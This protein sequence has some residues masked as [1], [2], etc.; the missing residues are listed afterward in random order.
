MYPILL[1]NNK[2]LTAT[3]TASATASG[4]DP[5]NVLDERTYTYWKA[6]VAG[7][8]YIRGAWGTAQAVDCVGIAGHN[9]NTVG[10]SV[11]VEHSSNGTDWIQDASFVP[12]NN[13]AIALYFTPITA[14]YWRLRI[15]NSS[16]LPMVGVLFFGEKILF[17]YPAVTPIAF[18][19]EGII[20]ESTQSETGNL[21][22]SVVKF[23]DLILD[24]TFQNFTKTFFTN[25]IKPFWDNH[26][27]LLKHFFYADDLV[28]DPALVYYCRCKGE[29]RMRPDQERS[30]YIS[31][32]N[33]NF[34]CER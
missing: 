5:Q 7:T 28:N 34:I 27:K 23:N 15:A 29:F 19:D 30:N 22:G 11:Y 32:L 12:P 14:A 6:N 9:F 25:S 2:L 20:S 10:A 17:E 26:G 18:W 33:F 13:N 16:G 1:Y 24:R 31:T 21:L 3:L 4:Y 8:N